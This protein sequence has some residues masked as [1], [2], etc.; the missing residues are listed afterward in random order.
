[1]KEPLPGLKSFL[2]AAF[3]PVAGWLVARGIIPDEWTLP[4]VGLLAGAVVA[5]LRLAV[6][7]KDWS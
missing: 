7:K 1:M 3:L 4:F 5:F 6:A 2:T